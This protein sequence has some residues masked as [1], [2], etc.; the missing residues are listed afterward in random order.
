MCDTLVSEYTAACSSDCDWLYVRVFMDVDTAV[1]APR[2]KGHDS[3]KLMCDAA[4]TEA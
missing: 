1:K 4:R 3:V 2:G